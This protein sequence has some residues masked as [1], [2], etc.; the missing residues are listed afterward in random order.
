MQNLTL[1]L[2]QSPLHWHNPQANARLFLEETEYTPGTD[3]IVLPEMFTTE[4]SMDTTLAKE[5]SE[6]ALDICKT[7]SEQTQ[8][9]VCGSTMF[10]AENGNKY[11]RLIFQKP[12]EE[13]VFYDKRH[14]FSLAGEEKYYHP[15]QSK[16]I[17]DLKG[18]KIL[19][20]VCYDLRFPVWSRR[21]EEENYDLL[22]YTAN[23]PERRSYAWRSLG[24]A[25]AIENQSYVAL[26]NRVGTDG[27]GMLYSGDSACIDF[28]GK[29]IAKATPFKQEIVHT[30]LNAEKLAIHRERFRFF[31]DRDRFQIL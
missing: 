25:R 23:W 4:F 27:S 10:L 12:G 14:L 24:V 7:L 15:G 26:V 8:A 29:A 20:L 2:V 28:T 16:T 1:T 21:T 30:V 22:I 9:A 13:P 11:N 18:W 3:L 6:T 19:P 5:A 17:I 31:D